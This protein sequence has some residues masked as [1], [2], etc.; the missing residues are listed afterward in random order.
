[1]RVR[2][3]WR[4]MLPLYILMLLLLVAWSGMHRR[5]ELR[6]TFLDVGQGDSCVIES[7]SGKVLVIDTGRISM[8]GSDDQGRETV[9]PFLRSR[10]IN[11]IDML[12]LTHPDADHVGGAASIL[13]RFPVDVLLLNGQS[14]DS[15]L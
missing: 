11:R 4:V 3:L 12:L 8:D 13:D 1:M 6:V 7:P 15:P 14:F 2:T 10:G 9:A 5:P